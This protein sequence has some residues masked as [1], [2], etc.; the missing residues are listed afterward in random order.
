M[1]KNK[2]ILDKNKCKGCQLCVVE[3]KEKIIEMSNEINK[4]GY[5]P[6]VI[7]DMS[8]CTG[9]TMC[10]IAC[11]EAIIEVIREED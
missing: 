3:C 8:K 11:P 9:C 2:V 6:A 10:A 4:L 5:T 7:T 1:K